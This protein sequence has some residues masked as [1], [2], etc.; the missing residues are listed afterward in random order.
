MWKFTIV[1][2]S[3]GLVLFFG[4]ILGMYQA[5]E[6]MRSL[7]GYDDPNLQQIVSIESTD[8]GELHASVLGE[9]VDAKLLNEKRQELETLETFNFFSE[10]GKKIA[11]VVE[12]VFTAAI[13]I[14]IKIAEKIINMIPI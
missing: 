14:F 12:S 10:L 5:N 3:F 6:S 8:D 9:E 11:S 2:C 7:R 13:E 1:S 4:V